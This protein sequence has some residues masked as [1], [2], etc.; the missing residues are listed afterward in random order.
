[1]NLALSWRGILLYPSAVHLIL[2]MKKHVPNAF[3]IFRGFALLGIAALFFS[4]I[5]ERYVMAYLLFLLAAISDYLDGK[6]ARSWAIESDFG[7]IFDP[8]FDKILILS[9]FI[10]LTP[11][12]IVHPLV[13]VILLV[14]DIS[15]DALRNMLLSRGIVVPAIYTAKLKTVFQ[16]LMLN[17]I[18][19][20]IAFPS[21]PAFLPLAQLTALIAVALSLWSGWIYVR[22]FIDF[23]RNDTASSIA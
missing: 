8:L 1:M 21:I 13:F 4:S 9:L 15:T 12:S 16:M 2:S 10:L 20:A 5:E 19:L 3:T 17:F 6:I 14:R 22:R 7:A 18:L 23:M 11:F